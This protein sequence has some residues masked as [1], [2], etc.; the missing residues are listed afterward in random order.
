MLNSHGGPA[1]TTP[2][3][4]GPAAAAAATSSSSYGGNQWNVDHRRGPHGRLR[5]QLGTAVTTK[6]GKALAQADY[7]LARE[8]E[9]RR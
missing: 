3:C 1:L 7:D 6:E 8:V 2:T 4:I 5:R 9:A